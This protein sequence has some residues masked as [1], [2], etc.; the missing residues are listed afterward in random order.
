MRSLCVF[1]GSSP[2]FRPAYADA[3][4]LLGRWLGANGVRLIYGGGRTGLMG[5]VAGA[6]LAAGGEVIG[7]MPRALVDREI[8]H[9]SL[10]ELHIVETMHQ[11]KARMADLADAFLA[12]PGGFGTLDELC[13]ILTWAQL[14]IHSKP[15]GLWNVEGY[16]DPLLA[17]FDHG[18]AEG[19]LRPA[20]RA[21]VLADGSLPSL[22]DAMDAWRPE[23]A[24]KWP[25]SRP[26]AEP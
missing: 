9:T 14:H 8:A 20:H 19:F 13:E 6:A 26:P 25:D 23:A 22:L 5:E 16:F 3:A 21:L 15:C 17:L 12:M 1:C 24:L 4:R 10:T 2:G 18:V 7:V 11:R